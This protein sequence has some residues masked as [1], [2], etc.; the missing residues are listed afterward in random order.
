MNRTV[1]LVIAVSIPVLVL[2][3]GALFVLDRLE[4]PETKTPAD[5]RAVENAVRIAVFNGCGR[6]GLAATFAVKLREMGYDVVNG[7]GENAD[8]FDYPASAI[9][10]RSG[11]TIVAQQVA[12]S[13]GIDIVL[14]QRANDPYLIEDV[15]VIL[16]RDW[17][18][19]KPVLEE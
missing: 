12:Q 3:L 5:V 13:L 18:T 7:L 15:H 4:H 9:V 1:Q 10:D 14:A 19:L 8:T 17:N 16:G 2:S 6:P 11:D